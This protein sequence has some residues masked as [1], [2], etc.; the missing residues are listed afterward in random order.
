MPRRIQDPDAWLAQAKADHD[1]NEDAH[2]RAAIRYRIKAWLRG[3]GIEAPE[4]TAERRPK[5]RTNPLKK[6]SPG[7]GKGPDLPMGSS[8]EKKTK[9]LGGS[10]SPVPS[11]PVEIPPELCAWRAARPGRGFRVHQAGVELYPEGVGAPVLKF[12][13]VADALA[14]VTGV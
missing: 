13:T 8:T 5:P 6:I 10:P 9:A 1:Q 7:S 2:S 3:R 14:A 4:W 11:Q 12:T